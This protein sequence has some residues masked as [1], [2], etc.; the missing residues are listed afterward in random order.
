MNA[1]HP[2]FR[3]ILTALLLLIL[4]GL[5][6]CSSIRTGSHLDETNN[7]GIYSTFSWIADNPYIDRDSGLAISPLMQAKI[8]SAIQDQLEFKG[9]QYTDDREEADFVVSYTVGSRETLRTTSYP[10]AYHGSW[11]WHVRGSYYYMREH[12]EHSYTEGTL[13]IDIFDGPS[14]KPVWHGWAEKTITMS[15]RQNPDAVIK[16]SVAKLLD[17]F[18]R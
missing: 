4:A 7:F 10:T 8:Q 16:D 5:G 11:G 6:A 13:A 17:A 9:Y 1:A 15:D 3:G 12:Q 14:K 18:P 2:I